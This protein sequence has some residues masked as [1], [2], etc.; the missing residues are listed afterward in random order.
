MPLRLVLPFAT[1][2]RPPRVLRVTVD[3]GEAA[4][5][6]L[7]RSPEGAGDAA[8]R[9]A[10]RGDG[11]PGGA[12]PPLLIIDDDLMMHDIIPRKLRRVLG[13]G[14]DT[15]TAATPEDGL[16][17]VAEL[18]PR[19]LVVLSDYDLRASMDGVTLLV[20]A[21]RIHPASTRILFSGHSREE[22]GEAALTR[23][24]IHAFLEKPMRLD[25]MIPALVD[26]LTGAARRP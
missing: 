25:E 5:A 18:A 14:P 9:R 7:P 16:R 6:S 24:E 21:A 10:R 17:L 23:Q 11:G 19:P 13:T 2:R 8:A 4:D 12:W 1:T 20:E 3:G 22:I 15:Y 26:L